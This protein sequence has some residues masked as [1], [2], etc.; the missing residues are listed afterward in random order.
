MFLCF[1]FHFLAY[2]GSWCLLHMACHLMAWAGIREALPFTH[3]IFI[4][5]HLL[6]V[7]ITP[8]GG[9]SAEGTGRSLLDKVHGFSWLLTPVLSPQT[10]R[11]IHFGK[12][13]HAQTYKVFLGGNP[14]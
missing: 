5:L 12:N 8:F 1:L 13:E 2:F 14:R 10:G 11:S 4:G 6:T 9:M 3:W 7:G